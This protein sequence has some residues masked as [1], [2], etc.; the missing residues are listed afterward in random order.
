M[1]SP[2][3]ILAGFSCSQKLRICIRPSGFRCPA[4]VDLAAARLI[5]RQHFIFSRCFF[6]NLNFDI[7]TR[8]RVI[9][10]ESRIPEGM[11]DNRELD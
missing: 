10:A 2:V 5:H 7:Q 1:N 3:F 8:A 11:R 4:D 9:T 6:R